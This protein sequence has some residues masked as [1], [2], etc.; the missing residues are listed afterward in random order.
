MLATQLNES[1]KIMKRI[2]S[3]IPIVF[4]TLLFVQASGQVK[5]E[6]RYNVLFIVVDDLRPELGCYGARQIKTPNI[7]RLAAQGLRFNRAY[8]QQALCSP[9]RTS[10]LTGLRPDATRVYDLVTH[11]RTTTPGVVTLPQLFKNHGYQ[12]IA[13]GKIFHQDLGFDPVGL[14]D[15]PSWSEAVWN[16][17]VKSGRGYALDENV[18]FAGAHN[19]RGPAFECADL[20]DTAYQDGLIADSAVRKLRQLKGRRFFL[21]VGFHKPHLPF[22]APKKY[23]DLYRESAIQLPDTAAPLQAPKMALQDFGELRA[24][25]GIPK[26]GKL[27]DSLA[28]RLI[29][30]YYASVSY[31]DAQ[32]G[33]VLEELHRLKLD[34]NTIVVLWG[35]HGWKLNDYGNWCKHS[36][37]EVDAHS[38]LILYSPRM[39]SGGRS[40]DALVELL[41]IFPTLCEEAA[42]PRPEQVQGRSLSPL[43]NN[44]A[45]GFKE[46]AFSQYPRGSLM[47]YSLRTTQFRYTT[48]RKSDG[49]EAAAELYDHKSDPGEKRNVA[50]ETAYAGIIKELN[51]LFIKEKSAWLKNPQSVKLN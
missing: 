28:R 46:V 41:D 31:V 23:W 22:T 17:E 49:S 26:K 38:P 43:L 40:T 7:D 9:S 29:H 14:E 18:A 36:N 51:A 20:P 19:G 33:R 16:P 42:L 30:G 13:L 25:Q 4:L 1:A 6:G 37:M 8:C 11:F 21:A 15:A 3:F 2:A 35:D 10:V 24:Y 39:K 34:Q 47:G 48:W 5:K 44:P 45:Q 50:G 27:P 32:V 12:S